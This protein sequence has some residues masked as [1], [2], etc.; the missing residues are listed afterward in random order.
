MVVIVS[1]AAAAAAVVPSTV[2]ESWEE[3]NIL[4]SLLRVLVT[5]SKYVV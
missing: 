2:M 5:A 3:G 1:V 4:A